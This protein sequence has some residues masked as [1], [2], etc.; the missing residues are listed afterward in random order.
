MTKKVKRPPI[1][2]V[3]IPTGEMCIQA[4]ISSD[5]L[6]NLRI[7]GL[8]VKGTHWY[9]LPN[10][11]RIIWVRDLVRDFLVN[12]ENPAAHKRAT[13]MYLKSLPSSDVYNPQQPA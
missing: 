7:R 3:G 4:G 5:T 9:T 1:R 10:S 13:D 12:G 8:L 2:W 6:K 11:T